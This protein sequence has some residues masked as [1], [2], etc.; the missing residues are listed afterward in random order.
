MEKVKRKWK[1]LS[2]PES[3]CKR[4]VAVLGFT[5]DISIAEYVRYAIKQR[6]QVDENLVE[7]EKMLEKEIKEWRRE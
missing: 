6:L 5:G 2:I 1:S 3:L 4:I 7:E